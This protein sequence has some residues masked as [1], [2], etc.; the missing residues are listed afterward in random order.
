MA[1][2]SDLVLW[3][4]ANQSDSVTFPEPGEPDGALEPW[5]PLYADRAATGDPNSLAS[6][7]TVINEGQADERI[8]VTLQNAGTIR[9]PTSTGIEGWYV[10]WDI[11]DVFGD[12]IDLGF[13]D[14]AYLAIFFH[15]ADQLPTGT[16]AYVYGVCGS[17]A[18]LGDAGAYSGIEHNAL[19]QRAANSFNAGA[20]A[21]W[22]GRTTGTEDQ[23][24]RGARAHWTQG[25]S[26]SQAR[27]TTVL[28]NADGSQSSVAAAT[29]ATSSGN[30]ET[31]GRLTRIGVVVGWQTAAGVNGSTL[32]FS[33]RA[34][35]ADIRRIRTMRRDLGVAYTPVAA[36]LPIQR[37]AILGD[38][39]GNGTET[40]PYSGLATPA[41]WV[42]RDAGANLGAWPAGT[43]P[44]VG[45]MPYYHLLMVADGAVAG[46][47]C[48]IRRSTNGAVM[49]FAFDTQITN[50]I[51]DVT[52]LAQGDP[53][54]LFWTI[55]ANDSQDATE[56]AAFKI[57]FKRAIQIL[58]DL[59]PDMLIVIR[60][61]RTTDLVTYAYL[62]TVNAHKV[63]VVAE[64]GLQ[65]VAF[66][67]PTSPSNA[68]LTDAIHF[69]QS[70]D[71]GHEVMAT[72]DWTALATIS[73]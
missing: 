51:G 56:A 5:I 34:M 25:N 63:D 67:S 22:A 73:S 17:A 7:V 48:I 21:G 31:D 3:P 23:L 11:Q 66:S 28:L 43:T 62:A 29:T 42:I 58:R 49:T 40:G 61:E 18:N 19:G 55:G 10:E 2:Q 64:L 65:R 69:S 38:S 41:G 30:A 24:A 53:Q 71:G 13:E 1:G 32:T 52:A 68:G 14:L 54:V 44:G 36:T 59:Y 27:I 20:G 60:D 72:R 35:L 16:Y 50:L 33:V 46:N 45:S 12:I 70:D 39:N 8:R 47:R 37:I 15:D 4:V 26:L 9:L 6:A 57:Y